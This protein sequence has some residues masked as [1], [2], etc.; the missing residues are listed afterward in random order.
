MRSECSAKEVTHFLAVMSQ[1]WWLKAD[2]QA[3]DGI[4]SPEPMER[5]Q[6]QLQLTHMSRHPQGDSSRACYPNIHQHVPASAKQLK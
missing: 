2:L 3:L 1:F 4:I 5:L 6:N